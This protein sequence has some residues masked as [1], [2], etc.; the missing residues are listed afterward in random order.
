MDESGRRVNEFV[1]DDWQNMYKKDKMKSV[2]RETS[3]GY[4]PVIAKRN[5]K[6]LMEQC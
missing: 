4:A 3:L 2:G 5:H 6:A 1:T